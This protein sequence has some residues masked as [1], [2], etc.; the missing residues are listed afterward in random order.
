MRDGFDGLV[1]QQPVVAVDE[2]AARR[3]D[4]EILAAEGD[5]RDGRLAVQ[6]GVEYLGQTHCG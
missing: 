4:E 6:L 2:R 3:D 1:G 5:L